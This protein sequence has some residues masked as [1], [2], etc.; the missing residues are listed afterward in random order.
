[1]EIF[2]LWNILWAKKVLIMGLG[3]L[4]A[5]SGW[6]FATFHPGKPD[7]YVY[8]ALL[9]IGRYTTQTGEIQ[10][11]ES[12][13]DLVLVLNH[14]IQ[15]VRSSVPRGG[16]SLIFLET[17][18][19]DS[20]VARQYLSRALSV[21]SERHEALAKPLG[22]R[23]LHRSGLILEPVSTIVSVKNSRSKIVVVATI[24]GLLIGVFYVLFVNEWR[25]RQESDAF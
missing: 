18:H 24:L 13:N 22:E 14:L 25:R 3:V 1:M 21:I 6:L 2:K 20:A 4:C 23:L 16:G 10:V 19:V 11:L 15:D 9:Q 5:L 8:T 7:K 17:T 12:P